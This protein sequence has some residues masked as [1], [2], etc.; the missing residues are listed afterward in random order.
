MRRL[1][2]IG[3]VGSAVLAVPGTGA[4]AATPNTL[5]V[6]GPRCYAT[7]QAAVK[8]AHSG[9]TVKIGAGRFAGG[10]TIDR[11]LH[12]VGVGPSATRITGGGPVVTIGSKSAR[13]TVSLANLA[14]TG[15]MTATNPQAPNCGPDVPTCGPG[16]A[17]ATALGGG[18]EAF[19]G[20]TVTILDS[21]ITGNRASPA[22]SVPSVRA[23]CPGNVPCPASFGDGAGIDDWGAMRL[24]GTT[25]SDNHAEAVQSDGGGVVVESGASLS[26]RDS[27]IS[28]N[29]ASAAAPT[30]RFVAGG[31]IFV[32]GG[33]LTLE[34]SSIDGN[35]ASLANSFPSPYPLQD[36]TDTAN[37]T[38]GGV[39]LFDG[40]SAAIRDSRLDHNVV[41]VDTPAD[42]AFGAD[43][44]LC[45]CGAVPLTVT[46][47]GIAGNTLIAK[48]SSSDNGPSGSTLEADWDT[49]ITGTRIAGNTTTVTTP[50]GN[51]GALGAVVLF[52]GGPATPT[53]T[54]SRI[55]ANTS[56]ANAPNGIATVQ[57]AGMTNNGPLLLTDDRVQANRAIANGLSGSAEGAGIWNGSL[58]GDPTPPLTLDHTRV[59]HNVLSGSAAIVRQGAG[60]FTPGLPPTLADSVVAHN[61]PDQCF[62][63]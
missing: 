49:T 43:A 52:P 61:T 48:V 46:N 42:Q 45:A 21:V 3:L 23:T 11:N 13:A 62:G 39:F 56:T 51:A 55:T 6:G 26:L 24:V 4:L 60:I 2:L 35:T 10:V 59:I 40:S 29:S 7:I 18:V 22:V 28:R 25:V 16:Y 58:F 34:G 57:G 8:A 50:D 5:C 36:G 12:L 53:I 1:T 54:D 33:S 14:I 15:G 19:P 44:A 38:G 41:T 31:G 63:C 30:G 27:T 17:T 9:A 32:D 20:T 37:S 47:S